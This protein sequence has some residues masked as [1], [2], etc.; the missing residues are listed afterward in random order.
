MLL[1]RSGLAFFLYLASI[2]SSTP[3]D[4]QR[5]AAVVALE[6]RASASGNKTAALVE[7]V[8]LLSITETCAI[9]GA[10]AAG[11]SAVAAVGNFLAT[12]IKN[13]SDDH[14]CDVISESIQPQG[15]SY[16]YSASGRNCDTTSE[17]KTINA[18]LKRA[19]NF[20]N[21]HNANQACFKLTHG[22]TWK[23]LLQI[24]A[25]NRPIIEGKCNS[26]TYDINI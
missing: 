5:P 15:V 17:Q 9:I 2:A 7:P 14:R 20:M 8:I 4:G 10:G 18:A 24:A 16:Q 12:I 25:A 3:I 21:S 6:E 13:Q 19:I 1:K 22:G 23:G 26:V 11:I